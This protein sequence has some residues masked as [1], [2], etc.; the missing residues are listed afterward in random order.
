MVSRTFSLGDR[1]YVY[2]FHN[3]HKWIPGIVVELTGSLSYKVRLQDGV[4]VRRHVNHIRSRAAVA[5]GELN[6]DPVA[7]WMMVQLQ[8]CPMTQHH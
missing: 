7:S 6:A 8:I 1:V 5:G 4:V 3:P 2:D